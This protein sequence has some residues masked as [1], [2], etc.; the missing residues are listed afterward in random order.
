MQ[1]PANLTLSEF[2][3]REKLKTSCLREAD[4]WHLCTST[5]THVHTRTICF[6]PSL[7]P[8]ATQLQAECDSTEGVV[9]PSCSPHSRKEAEG[10]PA[11]EDGL[12]KALP[13]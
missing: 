6:D 7:G 10:E 2:Q 9:E 8:L 3:A 11:G 1:R 4:I 12:F 5:H 13:R